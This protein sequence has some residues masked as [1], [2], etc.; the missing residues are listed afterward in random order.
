MSQQVNLKAKGL[1]TYDNQLS[2]I[3]EGALLE[4]TNILINRLNIIESRRGFKIYGNAFGNSSTRVKQLLRYKNRI[5]RHYNDK[6]QFDSNN[7]GNFLQF[8]GNYSEPEDGIRIKFKEAAG[9]LYFT[10]LAASSPPDVIIII[11]HFF[12]CASFKAESTSS[13]LPE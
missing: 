10:A 3:P 12:F 1:F 9:N 11:L 2:S 4:A 13:V 5:L 8:S 6:L 7:E